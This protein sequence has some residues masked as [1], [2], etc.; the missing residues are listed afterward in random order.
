M[1]DLIFAGSPAVDH[2]IAEPQGLPPVLAQRLRQA[3]LVALEKT[4]QAARDHQA[5]GLVLC[6]SILDSLRASPAQVVAL[7]GLILQASAHGCETIWVTTDSTSPREIL[8]MLGEPTGLAFATPLTPWT[9][10]IRS[11]TVELWAVADAEDAKRAT[12]TDPGTPL[13]RRLLV[14]DGFMATSRPVEQV[15]LPEVINRP[16]TLAV[17]A[18]A[19]ATPL[20]SS[21]LRLPQLQPRSRAATGSGAYG[22]TLYRPPSAAPASPA[23]D[24]AE[25]PLVS[26][27]QPLAT[28]QVR[29]RTIQIESA[30]GDQETL[31]EELWNI[32]KPA[33]SSSATPAATDQTSEPLT[34]VDCQIACGTSVDRR[35]EVGGLAA[36][37]TR[38]LR[39][40]C[41]AAAPMLWCERIVAAADESLAPLG[42]SRSGGQPGSSN[43]FTSALA[44]IVTEQET[45]DGSDPLSREAAW[46]ALELLEAD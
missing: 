7:R 11:A 37:A 44:D 26:G 18:T 12:A 38:R 40:R 3:P 28:E 9:T 1:F 15:L 13:H 42:H 21:V 36:E 29:W 4:F 16:D 45:I 5:C 27:W 32:L 20:P 31:A 30:E 33:A 39:E 41:A 43:S 46:L 34:L 8:R 23:A 17:W 24:T 14:G 19:T 25:L 10:T 6:G 22:L 35:I 2:P